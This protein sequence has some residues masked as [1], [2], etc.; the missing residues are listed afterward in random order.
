MKKWL[1]YGL[2]AGIIDI[3]LVFIAIISSHP[4][5]AQMMALGIVQFPFSG[6]TTLFR[7][8]PNMLTAVVG[9]IITYFAIGAIIGL[10]VQKVKSKK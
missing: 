10:I 9:G 3:V 2:I 4:R 6:L 5:E 1:K 8:Y 7:I